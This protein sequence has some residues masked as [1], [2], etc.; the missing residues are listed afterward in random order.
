M[1]SQAEKLYTIG[2][3]SWLSGLPVK[4]IRYYSD[5][6][7]LPPK[8]VTKA[9][10]RLYNDAS[11]A[12]LELI[13][14]LREVGFDLSSIE[15]LLQGKDEPS[16]A[17]CLQLEVIEAQMNSLSQQRTLLR[18]ALD[19]DNAEVL[20]RLMRVM[21][22]A[23]LDSTERE[24]FLVCHLEQGFG[25]LRVDPNW[26]PAFWETMLAL[27]DQL[28][29]SQLEAWL[30]LAE[31]VADESFQAALRAQTQPFADAALSKE[32]ASTLSQELNA[33]YQEA[34]KAISEGFSPISPRGQQLAA[35]ILRLNATMMGRCND[36]AFPEWWLEHMET[37]AD[38]RMERYWT[39]IAVL[40]SW[41][42]PSPM[43][44]THAWLID[45]LR[46]YVAM[47]LKSIKQNSCS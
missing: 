33:A 5:E 32:A 23:R 45:G 2:E 11:L 29:E 41:G 19:A 25:G 39:L 16:A 7:L 24:A 42:S 37:T 3:V 6:G 36:P 18:A 1:E 22:R 43:A 44:Q 9:R 28:S 40:R 17:M 46:H 30:E 15:R 35:T 13:R 26:R 8:R 14:T 12:R 27:P 38:P 4:T 34:A 21:W 20:T 47:D 31:L 10:Y